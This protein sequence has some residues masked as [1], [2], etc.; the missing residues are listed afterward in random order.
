MGKPTTN[1]SRL[2]EDFALAVLP[3]RLPCAVRT[4]K[5]HFVGEDL[6]LIENYLMAK[7]A[8]GEYVLSARRLAGILV[9]N[10]ESIGKTA[11]VRH[12]AGECS[13]DA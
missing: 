9:K 4:V 1:E 6:Q 5:Q 12:R 3:A 8:R 11:V 13:C 2:A 10:G 7:N